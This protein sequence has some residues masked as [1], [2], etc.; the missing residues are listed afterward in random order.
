MLFSRYV[1]HIRDNLREQQAALLASRDAM[2]RANMELEQTMSQLD[3]LAGTDELTGLL[4]R[5][6]FFSQA[7]TVI[8]QQKSHTQ[9][10]VFA[11]VDLD[12][13]KKINDTYG[14]SGGDKVLVD[15]AELA[16]QHMD[17]NDVIGRYGG[18]EFVILFPYALEKQEAVAQAHQKLETLRLAFESHVFP[19]LNQDLR[20]TFSVGLTT[21]QA[22]ESLEVTFKRADEALY[23]AKHS[24]RNQ[25]CMWQSS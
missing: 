10:L 12:Y 4:N 7:E 23:R 8:E 18:E 20:M 16:M 2:Q 13:F 14:H 11:V 1:R 19:S 9:T 3:R 15:F 21:Y 17:E 24:G 5:R 6:R 22:S 25:I